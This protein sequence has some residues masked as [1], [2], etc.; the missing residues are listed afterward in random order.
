M[1][2][3]HAGPPTPEEPKSIT[4]VADEQVPAGHVAVEPHRLALP[5][6]AHRVLPSAQDRVA[7]DLVAERLDRLDRLALVA[8]QRP[9]AEEVVL[10]GLRPAGG[11]DA[12][13]RVE[14]RRQLGGEAGEVVHAR[15]RGGLAIEP[16]MDRPGVRI[17][18]VGFAR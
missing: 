9:A 18:G 1:T 7:P 15:P 5:R 8:R 3:S 10:A 2:V 14:E 13:E 16:A 17:A 11:V 4:A 12:T 6:R